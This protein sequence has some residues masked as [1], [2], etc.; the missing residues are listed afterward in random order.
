MVAKGDLKFERR[1]FV[2]SSYFLGFQWIW[3]LSLSRVLDDSA[4]RLMIKNLFS[5]IAG[6]SK[7]I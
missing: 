4:N 2:A 3:G 6:M 1:R 5:S 7:G